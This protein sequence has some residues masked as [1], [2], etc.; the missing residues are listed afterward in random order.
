MH[1][2]GFKLD[3]ECPGCTRWDRIENQ[4]DKYLFSEWE[5][6]VYGYE[7]YRWIRM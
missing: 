3:V 4:T 1:D 2:L 5:T 7:G 6:R